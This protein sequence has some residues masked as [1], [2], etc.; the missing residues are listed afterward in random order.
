METPKIPVYFTCTACERLYLTYQQRKREPGN[1][2]CPHCEKTI[3]TWSG[4]YNFTDW[5]RA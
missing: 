3:Y 4:H 5:Q 2:D 1:F